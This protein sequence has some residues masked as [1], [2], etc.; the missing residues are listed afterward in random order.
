MLEIQIGASEMKK[1]TIVNGKRVNEEDISLDVPA[2]IIN[3]RTYLPLRKIGEA[4]GCEVDWDGDTR[5]V[6]IKSE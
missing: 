5:T 4:L 2:E 1:A 6:I 3:D